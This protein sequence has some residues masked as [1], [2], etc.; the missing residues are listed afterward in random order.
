MRYAVALGSNLGDRAG[1][2]RRGRDFLRGLAKAGAPFR[3]SAI[4]ETSPVGCPPGS[5]PFLNAAVEMETDLTPAELLQQLAACEAAS[6]R[7]ANHGFHQPRT[8]DLDILLCGD[9]VLQTAVLTI[10]HPRLLERRFALQPLQDLNP[11]MVIPG[12]GLTVAQALGRLPADAGVA[13]HATRL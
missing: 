11:Q 4:Y 6:G 13:L 10:P 12:S 5:L 7:P 3:T 1:H 9:L 2:L 8:L